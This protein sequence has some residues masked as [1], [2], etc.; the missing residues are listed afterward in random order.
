MDLANTESRD[1]EQTEGGIP[2]TVQE[3]FQYFMVRVARSSAYPKRLFALVERVGADERW[4]FRT[5]EELVN[6]F[7]SWSIR[8]ASLS[9]GDT[10]RN[11]GREEQLVETHTPHPARR[12][13]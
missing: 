2:M 9:S 12:S 7:P 6:L 4:T 8:S 3:Q 10:K 1:L 13:I 5:G 11:S